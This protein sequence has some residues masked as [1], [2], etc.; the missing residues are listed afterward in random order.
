MG[1][2]STRRLRS[3]VPKHDALHSPHI[4]QALSVQSIFSSHGIETLHDSSS[5]LVPPCMTPQELGTVEASRRR[6]L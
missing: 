5:S 4:P 2:F 3:R 6:T 1:N